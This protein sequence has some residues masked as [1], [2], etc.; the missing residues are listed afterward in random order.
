M[1]GALQAV[2][3]NQ[4]SFGTPPGSQ[5]YTTPGTYTFVVPSGVTKISA[6]V[7]GAGGNGATPLCYCGCLNGGGAG[8]GGGLAWK[9]NMSVTSGASVNVVVG[10]PGVNSRI[11]T[12]S[13]C[14]IQGYYGCPGFYQAG[15]CGG[16]HSGTTSCYG[17]GSGGRGG[18]S[19][20]IGSKGGG[21]GGASGYSGAGG[22]GAG[23]TTTSTAGIGGGGGGG[24]YATYGSRG[25]I[26][27]DVGLFGQG[28]NGAA[29]GTNSAGGIGSSTCAPYNVGA[30]GGGTT[31]IFGQAGG[32]G[33]N[34]GA[35]I[36]WP[37]NTRKFP[38]T[39][40]GAP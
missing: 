36:V 4:R 22:H 17:G 9:N 7:V 3:Q 38:S 12:P 26:G 15:G 27:G 33:H 35:R 31:A 11:C 21:G 13:S 6:V 10:G 8:G 37:G 5:S 16:S 29:G 32:I 40:V 25:P 19:G 20:G 23:T 39:C 34:G 18:C 14:F 24:G 2:F 1:S 30:G 28:C